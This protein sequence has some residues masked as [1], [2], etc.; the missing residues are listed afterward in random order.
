LDLFA[1]I[2]PETS[3]AKVGLSVIEI[4]M[5]KK[6]KTLNWTKLERKPEEESLPIPE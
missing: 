3:K 2:V 1:E 4:I 5:D 6:D